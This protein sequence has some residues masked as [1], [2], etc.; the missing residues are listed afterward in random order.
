MVKQDF[1]RTKS[2]EIR[3]KKMRAE[4]TGEREINEPNKPKGKKK[5]CML[6]LALRNLKKLS[7]RVRYRNGF[8]V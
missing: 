2:E 1:K 6:W 3:S 4:R 8:H 7:L 5:C